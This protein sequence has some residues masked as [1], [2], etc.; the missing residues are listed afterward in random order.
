MS[1]ASL[2]YI[3]LLDGS[4]WSGDITVEGRLPQD[5]DRPP[6]CNT[7]GPGFFRTLGIP[8]LRGREFDA[9][10][11]SDAADAPGGVPP[12][13]VAVVN[14]RFVKEYLGGEDP[15]GR[16]LGFGTD[17]GRPTPIQVVGVVKD[18]KYAEVR[19][20][21]P[22]QLFLP[23]LESASPGP[24]TVYIATTLPPEAA[25]AAARAAVGQLDPNLPVS[26]PRTLEQQVRR[27][28]SRDRLLATLAAVFG[29]LATLLA[30]VGLYGVMAYTV[31]QRTREIGV[32]IA[33]GARA[34]AIRWM[35][36][37][38]TL[39]LAGA[40]I[41]LGVPAA[42]WLG[43]LVDSQLYG[44]TATD[45]MTAV[46]AAALLALVSVLAGLV[47]SSRAAR[48]QPTNALRYE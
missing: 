29:V 41:A 11:A 24:F 21:V 42:W 34:Q 30:V 28:L 1:S 44:V 31:A 22:A 46:S 26:S 10:D 2:S 6:A 16:R 40:G 43:R 23:Y 4:R 36:I 9:R 47:P 13:R 39:A 15:I 14:E 35:V 19:D 12:F 32:R 3:K 20:E 17:P 37:R 48:V 27:S 25:L 5:G 45:P 7:I 38:E 33:L 8:V 18:V